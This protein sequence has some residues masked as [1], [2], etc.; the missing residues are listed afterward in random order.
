MVSLSPFLAGYSSWWWLLTETEEHIL[1]AELFQIIDIFTLFLENSSKEIVLTLLLIV[2]TPRPVTH[3]KWDLH[4]ADT[5]Q[6]LHASMETMPTPIFTDSATLKGSNSENVVKK[7][8]HEEMEIVL[9]RLGGGGHMVVAGS[10]VPFKVEI[11][12]VK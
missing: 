4:A 11:G 10:N 12:G 2:H 9:L 1:S 6:F 3:V 5:F 8:Q 7:D